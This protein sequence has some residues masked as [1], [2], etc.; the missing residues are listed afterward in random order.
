MRK[1]KNISFL[2]KQTIELFN[3]RM[4]CGKD[5]EKSKLYYKKLLLEHGAYLL[6]NIDK[7]YVCATGMLDNGFKLVTT[8][9]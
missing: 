8:P 2:L 1:K 3:D 6:F 4:M 7:D 5:M 9:W